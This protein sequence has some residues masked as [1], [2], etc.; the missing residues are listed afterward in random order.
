MRWNAKL[1]AG[2][3]I[4]IAALYYWLILRR[5]GLSQMPLLYNFTFR[6]FPFAD[7]LWTIAGVTL[8]YRGYMEAKTD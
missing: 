5:A 2:I 1:I 6:L 8:L 4:V 3:V 7:L